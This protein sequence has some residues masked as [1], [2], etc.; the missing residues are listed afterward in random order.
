MRL[1]I[2]MKC[3]K[4]S[5]PLRVARLQDE[6]ALRA[7]AGFGVFALICDPCKRAAIAPPK[8]NDFLM[9]LSHAHQNRYRTSR[10]R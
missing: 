1:P 8:L 7:A 9:E 3:R 6:S 2:E 5:R 4:C 10:R